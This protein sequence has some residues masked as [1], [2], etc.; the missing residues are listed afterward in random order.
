VERG[1]TYL[2]LEPDLISRIPR[3]ST[4]LENQSIPDYPVFELAK[5]NPS[6][7][8]E[9]NGLDGTPVLGAY[10]WIP[11][12]NMGVIIELPRDEVF[13]ELNTLGPFTAVL[14]AAATIL[15]IASVILVTNRM[16][17]PLTLLTEVAER[18]S[19]GMWGDRV[20]EDREDELG[21]LASTFNRMS[22]QIY[23]LVTDLEVKVSERTSELERRALQVQ[24]ASEVARDASA[25]TEIEKLL[26]ETVNL[27]AERFRLYHVGVFLLDESKENAV[28]AAASSEGGKRMLLRDHKLEVGK[29]GLVGY[30][31]GTGKPRIALDVGEDAVHFANPDLPETRSELALP[32]VSGE[33]ILG[34]LDVQ[35]KRP[36]AFDQN[37]LAILQTMADQIAL[38]I[39]HAQVIQEQSRQAAERNT[40]IQ[41]SQQLSEILSYDQLKIASTTI[42]CDA[43]GFNRVTLALLEGEEVVVRSSAAAKSLDP[44]PLGQYAPVG[45]GILGQTVQRRTAVVAPG[46]LSPKDTAADSSQGVSTIS[47]PLSSRGEMLGALAIEIDARRTSHRISLEVVELLGAQVAVALDNARLFEETQISLE[48]LDSMYRS[49]ISKAWSQI[50]SQEDLLKTVET[51]YAPGRESEIDPKDRASLEAPINLRGEI[52]GQL[53]IEGGKPGEWSEE[54]REILQSVAEDVAEAL[55]QIR[56]ME[57]I[58]R[59]ATQLQTAAE[60]SRDATGL[61]DLPTLLDQAVRLVQERFDLYSVAVYLVDEAGEIAR[62]SEAAGHAS[63]ELIESG[64]ELDVGSRS[65]IGFVT[66]R[67]EYY[68]ASDVDKDS[69]YQPHPLLPDTKSEMAIPLRIGQR[70]LGALDILHDQFNAFSQDD[71]AVMTILGDQI[72]VAIQNARLFEQAQQIAERE[73]TVVDI[74]SKIRASKDMEDMLK[75]AVREL[76]M[77]LGAKDARIRLKA[78][79]VGESGNGRESEPMEGAKNESI[80]EEIP[81]GSEE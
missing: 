62:I 21:T 4:E 46:S 49:Q 18:I 73:K 37:D 80:E 44:T 24:T 76:R 15:T 11:E 79:Q 70:V 6:G 45:Q 56:L 16:L 30:V 63:K 34:A 28:L 66:H 25:I 7:T 3:Y 20:P 59:R 72:A 9:Y 42:L 36:N 39:D 55:E 67:G 23:D 68:L 78:F 48:Q 61:M 1:G 53:L 40:V 43:F 60:I 32:L 19:R 35:S 71:L 12:M 31:T 64:V 65:I 41:I 77:T 17:Q 38:A 5:S 14:V 57:E 8:S 13:T 50:S 47:I 10:E 75:T 27:I 51:E 74:T 29:V 33:T 22:T 52:I 58:Q 26:D 81:P 54:E 69:L 2:A